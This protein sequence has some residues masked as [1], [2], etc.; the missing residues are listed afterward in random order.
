[1]GVASVQFH[2]EAIGKSTTYNVILPERG[3]EPFPV[4][5]QRSNLVR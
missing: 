4:L 2:S 3:E 5:I 1:M